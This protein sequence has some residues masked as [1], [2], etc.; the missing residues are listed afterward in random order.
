M[1]SKSI[2]YIVRH[3][4]CRTAGVGLIVVNDQIGQNKNLLT[5]GTYSYKIEFVGGRAAKTRYLS[6]KK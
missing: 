1:N 3:C 4:K 5:V 2:L 6:L